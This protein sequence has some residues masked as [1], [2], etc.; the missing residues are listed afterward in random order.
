MIRGALAALCLVAPLAIHAQQTPPAACVFDTAAHL[1]TAAVILYLRVRIQGDTGTDLIANESLAATL[2]SRWHPPETIG[3][4]FYPYTVEHPDP[5]PN[6]H[7]AAQML[8]LAPPAG[9]YS[10]TVSVDRHLR[11]IAV[12]STSGD[13]A[14]DASLVAALEAAERDGDA[15]PFTHTVGALG[16]TLLAELYTDGNRGGS[17][18]VRVHVHRITVDSPAAFKSADVHS[19]PA[20]RRQ[21]KS[22]FATMRYVIN[23]AGRVEPSSLRAIEATSGIFADA[24]R[25]ALLGAKFKPARSGGCPVK[26]LVEQRVVF[27]E[28]Q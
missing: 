19:T 3:R 5:G 1:D 21:G 8:D 4:L 13:S 27:F 18:L 20:I 15:A 22:G 9:A 10:F 25:D 7:P 28:G 11:E 17:P 6:L 16:A 23:E 14:T 24:A 26:M 2:R 12:Q